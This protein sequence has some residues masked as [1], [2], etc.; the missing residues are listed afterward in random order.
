MNAAVYRGLLAAAMRRNLALPSS[1]SATKERLGSLYPRSYSSLPTIAQSSFWKQLIPKP[2]RRNEDGSLPVAKAVS[3]ARTAKEWNPATFY[4]FIFLF[5]GSMSIQ[6]ITLKKDFET[7][8]RQSEVKFGLL[9]E[10]I[11]R[12][13]RGEKVD[14]ERVLGTGV[15]TKE[16][17]WDSVLKELER[18]EVPKK[19][20]RQEKKSAVPIS[21]ASPTIPST[22]EATNS[23]SPAPTKIASASSFY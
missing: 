5:I 18:D 3:S 4:I 9:R 11:E 13:Q 17:E 20:G 22:I 8:M 16:A 15:P 14:V 7:F 23:N 10:V 2:L 12:V 21:S 1:N 19:V 6:M